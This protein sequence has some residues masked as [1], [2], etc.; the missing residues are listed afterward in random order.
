MP[1]RPGSARLGV[2][3]GRLNT[4]SRIK[5]RTGMSDPAQIFLAGPGI[6]AAVAA[7]TN[8]FSINC[9]TAGKKVGG[10][11]F[12]VLFHREETDTNSTNKTASSRQGSA[13]LVLKSGVGDANCIIT[14]CQNGVYTCQYR[15]ETPGRYTLSVLNENGR[16]IKGTPLQVDV[17]AAQAEHMTSDWMKTIEE[18]ESAFEQYDKHRRLVT[19]RIEDIK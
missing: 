11:T 1:P 14:D 18:R 5:A 4:K 16:D 3:L 6:G 2:D 12:T 13:S 8:S 7:V 15:L 9:R 17:S 19:N 10:E